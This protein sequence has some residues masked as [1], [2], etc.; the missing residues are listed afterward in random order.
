MLCQDQINSFHGDGFLVLR[1]MFQGK[2]LQALRQ[3]ADQVLLDGVAA[4]GPHHIYHDT[5]EGRRIYYRSEHM[6]SRADI[7]QAATVNPALLEAIGQCTGHPFLPINDSFVC[8]LPYGNVPINWHQDPF[9]PVTQDVTSEI[10]NFDV[11]IYLDRSTVENGC[12]WGIPGRHLIGQLD[13]SALSQEDFF[14]HP[15][16][17][18]M[19]MEPGDVLFHCISAL[20]GSAGNRT[21]DLRRIFYV[22]YMAREVLEHNYP[23]WVSGGKSYDA[24]RVSVQRMLELRRRLGFH[25]LEE[26]RM[27]LDTRGFV[28]TGAPSTPERHWRDLASRLSHEEVARLRDLRPAVL[29]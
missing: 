29:A 9:K 15:D 20:H 16:A 1:G 26:G 21:S 22:H 5:P 25:G 24:M 19:E 17:V 28:F 23:F 7:F 4:R 10:P 14:H 2:E 12:V 18:P 8:K 27:Q 6:W 11:D 13:L 3:A